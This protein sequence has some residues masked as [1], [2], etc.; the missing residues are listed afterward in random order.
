MAY[1][2]LCLG[3]CIGHLF[4]INQ[5]TVFQFIVTM[6]VADG[7]IYGLDYALKFFLPRGRKS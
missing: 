7:L 1:I 6:L 2:L 5:M 3:S 4:R